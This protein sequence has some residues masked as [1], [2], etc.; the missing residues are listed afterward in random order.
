MSEPESTLMDEWQPA[1]GGSSITILVSKIPLGDAE[2]AH[3]Q[4]KYAISASR[5]LGFTFNR[6]RGTRHC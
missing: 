5:L 2:I 4:D 1:A 3:P 6:L